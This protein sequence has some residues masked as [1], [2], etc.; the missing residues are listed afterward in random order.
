[1]NNLPFVII[2]LLIF[3]L[4]SSGIDDP[5]SS[6][7]DNV[8]T[9][10]V[11]DPVIHILNLF[12][13]PVVLVLGIDDYFVE[14]DSGGVPTQIAVD[15]SKGIISTPAIESGDKFTF[16][17]GIPTGQTSVDKDWA[18]YKANEE[19]LMKA[20]LS[21]TEINDGYTFEKKESY[22]ITVNP[23]SSLDIK[24]D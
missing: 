17:L 8:S 11:N 20:A 18:I 19:N 13:E 1:M 16:F 21:F 9:A 7:E 22:T 6:S 14:V 10:S 12:D 24:K 2:G 5:F 3:I 15:E 23:D 4:S